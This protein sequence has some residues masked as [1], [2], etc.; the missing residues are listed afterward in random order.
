VH[1]RDWG[2]TGIGSM[3]GGDAGAAFAAI[4]SAGC[5]L[6]F[7]PQLPESGPD[8]DMVTQAASLLPLVQRES[9]R[10]WR[11]LEPQSSLFSTLWA[12]ARSGRQRHDLGDGSRITAIPGFAAL[13]AAAQRH[14]MERVK[15]Q[16]I[17]PVSLAASLRLK[18]ERTLLDEPRAWQP[19]LDAMFV[20]L[21]SQAR[22]LLAIAPRVDLWIDEPCLPEA[23]ARG[24]FDRDSLRAW[25]AALAT[26]C[27]PR[28]RLGVHCCA[29]P[30]WTSLWDLA[31]ELVSIDVWSFAAHL[32]AE[33]PALR[34]Q[35]ERGAIAWGIVPASGECPETEAIL[36]RLEPVWQAVTPGETRSTLGS[37]SL[38]T[39]ACGLPTLEPAAACERLQRVGECGE[40]WRTR[41]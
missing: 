16:W 3:G 37:K 23:A 39:P 4:L 21:R 26:A 34:R 9:S 8:A 30:P 13:R 38:L 24:R 17:G 32:E 33:I 35:L 27:G 6:P 31:P 36:D 5:D 18:S 2:L 29:P 28:V 20:H 41:S 10:Q 12:R 19:L 1:V 25:Y 14:P 11:L 7:W 22:E 15:G 40:R